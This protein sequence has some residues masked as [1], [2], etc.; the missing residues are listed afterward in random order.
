MGWVALKMLTGDRAKYLGTVFGVA[1]GTLLISQQMSIFVGLMQRTANQI[2][3]IRDA[4]IWVMDPNVQN[5]DEIKPL[6]ESDIYRVRGVP[7]IEWAVKLYKGLA[8]ARVDDGSFRQVML[9]G[10]D[11][12]TLVGA[13]AEMI[14][15]SLADL[16]RP[17]AVIVDKAGYE[18]LWPDAPMEVGKTFEM[19]DRRATIVGICH[20]SA[21]F[22]TFPIMFSRYSQAMNFVAPERQRLSFVLAM[23]QSGVSVAEACHRI[24]EQ[25]GLLARSRMQFVWQTVW[26]YMAVTG[27]PVNFGI[28]V[29]LG[30]IVGTAIAGQTFYLF[31]LE[32]LRQFGAL[33]AMGVTNFRLLGMVLLQAVV[34]GS[35]GFAIGVGLTALF[36]ECTKNITHMAG[37]YMPWQIVAASALAVGIIV[38]LASFVSARKV[39]F[40]EPA[41]VFRG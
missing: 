4:Q 35:V 27:I 39:L 29:A 32:N 14:V 38:V 3:D 7:G 15:G 16:R 41:I 17:D 18:Y 22:Q 20:A 21:P 12:D 36:F 34:V 19:N 10:L 24:R 13:P 30:F 31:T 11:D 25:T 33:K 28:T 26:Y 23:P 9:M 8:R 2:I 37:F 1:F 5:A 40:L 6:S